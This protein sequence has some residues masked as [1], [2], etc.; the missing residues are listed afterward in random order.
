MFINNDNAQVAQA[1]MSIIS[2]VILVVTTLVGWGFMWLHAWSK[3]QDTAIAKLEDRIRI[4]S[5]GGIRLRQ[6]IRVLLKLLDKA[7]ITYPDP[8]VELYEN[9]DERYE[10]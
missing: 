6:Y 3:R 4:L 10:I 7:Q 5:K 2:V 8:P 1:W 9:Q